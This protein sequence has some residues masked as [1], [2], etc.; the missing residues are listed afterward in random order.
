MSENAIKCIKR[1]FDW[2]VV[3]DDCVDKYQSLVFKK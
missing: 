2:K 1:D 3:I